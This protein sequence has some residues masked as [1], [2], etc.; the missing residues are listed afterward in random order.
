[1][2]TGVALRDARARLFAAAE[3]VVMRDGARGL[4]SRAVTEEAG[5][6]KGVLHRHFADFDDF[7]AGLVRDRI[8]RLEAEIAE[9][10]EAAGSAT[11]VSNLAEA[12]TRIFTP[13]N[14]GLVG[15]VIA[16]DDLRSR[17]RETTPHGIPILTEA[18]A[19]LAA[20]LDA[21]RRVGRVT[22]DTDARTLAL[23]LI[24]TGHL[25]FAGELGALPDASA[26]REI[27]EA[28]T[29]GAEPG[30]RP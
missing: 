21:E 29:V 30:I 9:L 25:L 10:T 19:C 20:Y 22:A 4:T 16:R 17:L 13:V 7:L 14:L 23:T 15:I 6:A 1:M 26:V 11:L 12:L 18:G 3:R 2:P 27:V 24:G 5:V 28:I 8:A